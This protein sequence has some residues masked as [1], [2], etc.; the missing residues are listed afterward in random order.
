MNAN[1]NVVKTAEEL[2]E[3]KD[4][5][6][7]HFTCLLID[8]GF[9]LTDQQIKETPK[10]IA[11]AWVEELMFGNFNEEPNVTVFDNENNIDNMVTLTNIQVK[12]L[13]SHH[14]MPFFGKCHIAYIPNE[15]IIGLSKLSRIVNWFSRR[16]Q[17]Q[18]ELTKQISDYIVDKI[19]PKGVAVYIEATHTCMTLRGVNEPMDAKMK[20]CEVHG[21]FTNLQTK[22][23]FLNMISGK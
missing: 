18:E 23:E 7:Y 12:S 11:K 13:C 9:D 5:A 22:T 21:A 8:L 2:K 19:D 14:F 17:I 4:K 6:E 16:P 20:T 10:R 15:K 3:L 1:G